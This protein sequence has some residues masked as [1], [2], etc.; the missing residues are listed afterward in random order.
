MLS[1]DEAGLVGDVIG[2]LHALFD[3]NNVAVFF[4]AGVDGVDKLFWFFLFPCFL[5]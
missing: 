2:Q 1:V 5:R 3:A 4:R